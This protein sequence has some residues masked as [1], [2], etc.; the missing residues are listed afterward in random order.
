[1]TATRDALIAQAISENGVPCAGKSCLEDCFTD[2]PGIGLM[3]WYNEPNGNT[4]VLR[5]NA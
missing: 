1:M 5:A 2:E 4:R 3:L